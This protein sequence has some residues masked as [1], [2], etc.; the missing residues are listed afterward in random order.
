MAFSPDGNTIASGSSDKTIRLW[1][2]ASGNTIRTLTGH[3]T[4]VYSVAFSPDGNK[5][6]SGSSDK[7][8]WL[9]DAVSGNTIHT[10]TVPTEAVFSVAFS[11]DGHTIA[12][13]GAWD[14]RTVRLWDVVSGS[15][16][17]TL[18]GHT[19]GVFSVA[20]SPDGRT[21][22]SA[23][24]SSLRL[25][26]AVTGAPKNTL[27]GHIPRVTS[28]SFSPDGHTIASTGALGDSTIRL[29]EGAS[30]NIIRILTGHTWEISSAA[31][32]PD[33]R[34][35]ASGSSDKTVRLWDV[36]TGTLIQTLTEQMP[37]V[38]SVAFSPDGR[39]IASAGG[40]PG[41]KDDNAI[42]LWDMVSGTLIRTL[43]GHTGRVQSVTFSPDG[44]KIASA[45]GWRERTVRLWDVGTGTLIH[46]LTEHTARV[47]SVAFSPDGRTI[48]SAS[49]DN[50]VRLWDVDTGVNIQTLEHDW[51]VAS[52]AFSPDGNTIASGAGSGTIFLWDVG[53]GTLIQTLTGHTSIVNSVVFSPDGRTIA[54]GSVDGTVLLWTFTPYPQTPPEDTVESPQPP[55]EANQGEPVDPPTLAQDSPQW[56]LPEGAIARFGKGTISEITYSPDGTRLAVASGIG[57]WLYDTTTH[58]EVDLVVTG[59]GPVTSVAFSPDGNI[60][61]VGSGVTDL[62]DVRTG[63][64]IRTFRR[65]GGGSV[66]FSPDGNTIA[67]G[68]VEI[69]LWDIRTGTLIHTLEGHSS[70]DSIAFSPDGSTIASGGGWYDGTVRLWD[71]A[72][73]ALRQTFTGTTVAP[74]SIAFSPNGRRI[75]ANRD[76]EGAALFWNV[77]TGELLPLQIKLTAPVDL[78]GS[79]VAVSPN[80]RTVAI[81]RH[82]TVWLRSLWAG[83]AIHNTI[84]SGYINSIAFSPDGNTIATSDEETVQLWDVSTGTLTR[85]WNLYTESLIGT[86]TGHTDWISSVAFSPDGNT[87]AA[88]SHRNFRLW[89]AAT[90]ALQ[91]QYPR[92][93]N[94]PWIWVNSVAFSPD[95]NTVAT[96]GDSI[97]HSFI[98]GG[99]AHLWD[100]RTGALKQTLTGH[101]A[102][103][104]SVAFSPDGNTI[105]TGSE[106]PDNTI[107]LWDV[108]SGNTIHTLTEH[109]HIVS[110]VAFSPDGNTL[111]SASSGDG[112][113]RLWNLGS[114]YPKLMHTLPGESDRISSVAFR[115]DSRAIVTGSNDDIRVWDVASGTLQRTIPGLTFSV[116]FSPDGNRI[117]SGDWKEIR[118]WD[119]STGALTH[120][121]KGHAGYVSGLAFSPDGRTLVSGGDRGGTTLL[122]KVPPLTYTSIIP[123]GFSYFHVPLDVD[124]LDTVGDLR[125]KLGG[126]ANLLIVYDAA[127]GVWYNASD[128]VLITADLGIVLHMTA[129]TT[130]TFA[131]RSW[132]GGTPTIRLKAGSNNLIGL[133][134]NDSNL[135]YVSDI[136]GLFTPGVVASIIVAT[137]TEFKAITKAGD[138]GDQAIRGDAAYLI[139]ATT[140]ASAT[141]GGKGWTNDKGIGA[142]PIALTGYSPHTQTPVLAVEGTV[143]DETTGLPIEGFRV[144]VKNLSTQIT[145][146]QAPSNEDAQGKYSI[147]FVDLETVNAARVGD[148]LEISADS[149]N[150]LIGVK[151]VRHTVTSADVKRSRIELENLIAY[152]IPAETELLRNY[153]NPFNPETWIPYRLA[154]DVNV[155]LTIYDVNGELVRAIDVGH[156]IAAVYESRAKA[157]YWDG[158]NR[159][160]EQVASGVYFYS[161]SA[162]DFSATRKMVILK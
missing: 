104:F 73:G 12:S 9:W 111:A 152:E 15:L 122:W 29:W 88:G 84:R 138:P 115:P 127:S 42:R 65:A 140:D 82:D 92:T 13:T 47:W 57:V 71:A 14:D 44:N 25:W 35:I 10:L 158:R 56:H 120:T 72:S 93:P 70:V 54:S 3:T 90:G 2:V 160:G 116:A 11:P 26:D 131:G 39:T 106:P 67:A 77:S 32:S 74:Y 28:V 51:W 63:T 85:D 49:D 133:P 68:D 98:P 107:R 23:G 33:G 154:E 126:T 143:V 148:V 30:G 53:T 162:G 20:F 64:L 102:T 41:P 60:M 27:T 145:R 16:I 18:T 40:G 110:S 94:D 69:R 79:H 75:T 36:G 125:A 124:G 118:L 89:D 101:T 135:T 137:E 113:I 1:D 117:A 121:F 100:V 112:T 83:T 76:A 58:Q 5:I 129:E 55:G 156:Q 155:S 43:T 17:H 50:T 19:G 46:T 6:A 134:I 146:N 66:V 62:W 153:P 149:P 147:V 52:V 34:T 21:I 103:V 119:V 24:G 136:I 4:N 99:Y 108:A 61:A 141:I 8:I 38:F 130:V 7:T 45:G 48:A 37:V 151:P 123:K 128:T 144:K 59:W 161:L 91:H 139:T 142:A 150:P 96:G 78:R 157:I 97:I 31:F 22:A 80:G 159:L 86:L 105:A 95:G 81:G 132:G 114:P 109:T 87:I